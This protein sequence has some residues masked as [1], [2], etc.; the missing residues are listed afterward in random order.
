MGSNK[1]AAKGETI[2]A[3]T[4]CKECKAPISTKAESCPQ[5]GAKR[6]KQSSGCAVVL[7]IILVVAF[8]TIASRGCTEDYSAPAAPSKTSSDAG[9]K[10]HPTPPAPAK[11]DPAVLLAKSKNAVK[12]IESRYQQNR[13]N[14][15]KYYGTADQVKQATDDLIKLA[16]I[17]GAYEKSKVMDERKLSQKA[18]LLITKVSR[19]E[20]VLYA[21][22]LEEIFVKNGMDVTVR[23]YGVN[24]DR[25]SLKYALMSKP[26]I[27]QFQN[28]MKLNEQARTFSFKKIIYTDGYDS[29]WTVNL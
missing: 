1:E 14:L 19:Q 27:Y 2:M 11:P 16:V 10:A 18:N 12:E 23:A 7:A 29:T 3:M 4:T 24:K 25:L 15:K 6:K 20:R 17:E 22:T 21:S 26:M 5:C 9:A 8:L 28:Q 13:E